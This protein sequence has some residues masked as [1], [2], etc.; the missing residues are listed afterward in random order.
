MSPSHHGRAHRSGRVL[1]EGQ[2][3]LTW[4]RNLHEQRTRCS[5]RSG[6]FIAAG[7]TSLS[8]EGAK[9]DEASGSR[10]GHEH[11]GH[12]RQGTGS[13]PCCRMPSETSNILCAH[14]GSGGGTFSN[15]G[16]GR[17]TTAR[18]R[19][20][21]VCAA[22]TDGHR[23]RG[24][25]CARAANASGRRQDACPGGPILPRCARCWA[26]SACPEIQNRDRQGLHHVR[27]VDGSFDH[28]SSPAISA[29]TKDQQ[30]GVTFHVACGVV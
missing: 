4:L 23:P 19:C 17:R 25:T 12:C 28:A 14:L 7:D 21:F 6:I 20:R 15:V 5:I 22:S 1:H 13:R 3:K 16:A 8:I 27:H 24:R 9:A 29:Y 10:H 30:F 11:R 26:P 18:V 2:G